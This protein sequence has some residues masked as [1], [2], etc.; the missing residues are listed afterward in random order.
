MN[1]GY[2]ILRMMIS[3]ASIAV[4]IIVITSVWPFATGQFSID[5]PDESDIVWSYSSGVVTLSAPVG[6]NNGG[7]YAIEDVVVTITVTNSTGYELL[8][9]YEEWGTIAP[10]TPFSQTVDFSIDFIE[11]LS[12][13]ADWMIFN[14]DFFDIHIT[15]DCK[16]TFRLISFTAEYAL[17]YNWD[18]LI[19]DM[20]F[21]EPTLESPSPGTYQVIQ[22]YNI[23]TNE[24]L[25]GLGGSFSIELRNSTTQQLIAS[26]SDSIA[27][28]IDHRSDLTFSVNETEYLNLLQYDQNIDATIQLQ[29]PGMPLIEEQRQIQWV[30]PL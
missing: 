15:I 5:L 18:G 1:W 22:P 3:M 14:P 9:S 11:L 23:W 17:P 24:L 27:L 29:L 7:F 28:G 13:G 25:L 4:A 30:S 21:G 6:I 16:Y 26:S 2:R 19:I 8:D 12:A 10:G 20:G